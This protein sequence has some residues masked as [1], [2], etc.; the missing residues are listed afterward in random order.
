MMRWTVLHQ[1]PQPLVLHHQSHV[2]LLW[3]ILVFKWPYL[4]TTK[5]LVIICFLCLSESKHTCPS[6][7]AC[8]LCASARPPGCPLGT[9]QPWHFS[10]GQSEPRCLDFQGSY[11]IPGFEPVGLF[12]W[13]SLLSWA[14]F[15]LGLCH[16]GLPPVSLVPFP[17]PGLLTL[18]LTWSSTILD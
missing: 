8:V 6:L 4:T 1:L 15:C 18:G 14:F 17:A 3:N 16:Q 11:P 9:R 10:E 2:S 12:P 7:S 5:M 13:R